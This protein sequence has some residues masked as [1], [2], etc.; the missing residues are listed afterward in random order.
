MGDR[1][2]FLL[3][4]VSCVQSLFDSLVTHTIHLRCYFLGIR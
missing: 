3:G 2:N 1:G 4:V